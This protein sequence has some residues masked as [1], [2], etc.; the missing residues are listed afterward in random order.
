MDQTLEKFVHRKVIVLHP[1][2][3][4]MQAARAMCD[5]HVGCVVIADHDGQ[6][7]GILTDRDLVCNALAY[8]LKSE[9]RLSEVMTPEPVTLDESAS[10]KEAIDLMLKNGIRRIPIT[11]TLINQKKKCVGLVTLDE[12]ITRKLIE[13]ES[14]TRIVQ[15]QVKD[16]AEKFQAGGE[17]SEERSAAHTEQT[18]H[19]FYNVIREKVH[20]QES[21]VQPITKFLL[22]SIVERMH[23]SAAAKLISQ[24]PANLQ[25]ELLDL[26]AGPNRSI[27]SRF[28]LTELTK[29]YNFS[30]E[31]ARAVLQNFW[32]ALETLVDQP[33][34]RHVF[35]QLPEDLK[36]V[37]AHSG[38]K[39]DAA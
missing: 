14:L 34:L 20:L 6:V 21:F 1:D 10:L 27:T 18:E 23:Y 31:S 16:F 15:E 5:N 38:R 9:T 17:R 39:S 36:A 26:P 35:D 24:L 22:H 29:T 7:S 3:T 30:E 25:D 19:R 4:A 32:H 11:H 8:N 2:S 33:E 28:L 37:F 12:L 13:P